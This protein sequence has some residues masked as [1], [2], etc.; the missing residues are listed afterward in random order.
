MV[1]S[2]GN[3]GSEEN[4]YI[5]SLKAGKYA[6]EIYAYATAATTAYDFTMQVA[7]SSHGENVIEIKNP[8]ITLDR[9]IANV[10]A[11]LQLPTVAGTHRGFIMAM[12]EDGNV[13]GK[14][15]V[16]AK[17]TGIPE[18]L[19]I[20]RENVPEKIKLGAVV[21]IE[22]SAKNFSVKDEEVSLIFA[23]YEKVTNRFIGYDIDAK[24]VKAGEIVALSTSFA[25]PTTGDYIVKCFIW[26]SINGQQAISES[27]EIQVVK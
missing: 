19:V 24:L 25:M 6:L 15:K 7:N 13:L 14:A 27:I 26:D 12:D 5:E 10:S 1:A 23:V 16:E 11:G 18:G 4:I 21:D 9:E 17:A 3:G 22:V 8:N 20:Q 2:S